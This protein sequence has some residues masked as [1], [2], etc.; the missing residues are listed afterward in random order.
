MII[1]CTLISTQLEN[2]S[3]SDGLR[4]VAIYVK[5]NLPSQDVQI[6]HT[7]Y[8]DH[9][10]V[11]IKINDNDILLCG[12]IYRSPSGDKEVAS[13]SILEMGNIL[14]QSVK[15][16]AHHLLIA[17]DFNLKDIDWENE[18]VSY[19]Q[20]HLLQ[21]IETF[22]ECY[23]YQHVKRPTRYRVGETPHILDLIMTNEEGMIQNIDHF[24]GL[25][26]SDHEILLFELICKTD[27][28]N[29]TSPRFDYRKGNYTKFSENISTIDWE[30]Y[31]YGDINECYSKFCTLL[32]DAVTKYVPLKPKGRKRK[33]IFMSRE[34]LK[35]KN[36]KINL[37]RKYCITRDNRDLVCFKK[38]RNNLRS[39]TRQLRESFENTLANNMKQNPKTF[40]KYALSRMKTIVEI[41]T[42]T[43]SDGSRAV[44]SLE[45]AE[46][47]NNYFCSAFTSE[48][49]S[50]IP[51]L[52]N[53]F[54]GNPLTSINIS[55][56]M[57]MKKLS[58]LNEYKSPGPDGIH[59]YIL[60]SLA[61]PLSKPITMIT[62]KS[63]E[64]GT[65][66][67]QWL[68]AL[69][70]AIH[71]KG[72]RNNVE[73]YRPI[74]LISIISKIIE[75]FIRDA[76]VKHMTDNNLFSNEQHGF[77]PKRNC[78]SQLLETLEIWCQLLEEGKCIDVIYTDFSKAFDSVPHIRLIK[79]LESYGINGNLLN[80]ILSFLTNRKQ[81]V[82]IKSCMSKWSD[83]KSGVPQGS[84]LGPILFVVYIN[85]MP[86]EIKN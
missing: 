65:A 75:S 25:G 78:V 20:E 68:E 6:D 81:R 54:T 58:S 7:N 39:K 30:T 34:A 27:R 41:P 40:W 31:L 82:R 43:L 83:V 45:K 53:L 5:N 15:R 17:G 76:L 36:E 37:W 21:F 12:C 74:S 3:E 56:E 10:W 86:S 44:S 8:R 19:N 57:V 66:P 77:L 2:N 51:V 18:C 50:C 46:K 9:V 63:L 61:G 26:K 1:N 28:R 71:K 49:T 55:E 16:E 84:V 70:T 59:P 33:N 85:D 67:M 73:N 22:Q 47:L 32:N 42:L 4:G 80:W 23:L 14:V 38:C 24:P 35:L 52:N 62:R 60:K 69:I 29:D 64:S 13:R 48:D 11:E 79:K 72:E